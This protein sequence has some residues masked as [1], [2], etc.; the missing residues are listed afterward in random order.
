MFIVEALQASFTDAR[1]LLPFFTPEH[2]AV[3][4]TQVSPTMDAV[5]LIDAQVR[6]GGNLTLVKTHFEQLYCI[7][8]SVRQIM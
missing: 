3:I 6:G 8:T 4:S 5:P 2:P 7:T 1:L